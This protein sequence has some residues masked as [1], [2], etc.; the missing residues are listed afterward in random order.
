MTAIGVL[1][2]KIEE[3]IE[4]IDEMINGGLLSSVTRDGYIFMG[5]ELEDIIEIHIP[6]SIAEAA[7]AEK[8][9]KG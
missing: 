6:A 4:E 2:G 5:Q 7:D 1:K 8:T 9:R 3:R